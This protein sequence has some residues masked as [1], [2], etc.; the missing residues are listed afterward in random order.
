MQPSAFFLA[1]ED[2]PSVFTTLALQRYP[3]ALYQRFKN[4]SGIHW[5]AAAAAI[6][7]VQMAL[8]AY[9]YALKRHKM[10]RRTLLA[11]GLSVYLLPVGVLLV[12]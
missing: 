11:R 5:A 3:N 1:N 6:L 10:R 4:L 8:M 9:M 2:S 12:F 7:C